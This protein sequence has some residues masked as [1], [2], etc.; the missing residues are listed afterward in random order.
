MRRSALLCTLGL[1]TCTAFSAGSADVVVIE[2]ER[3]KG[4]YYS[5]RPGEEKF[6]FTPDAAQGCSA[7][8]LERYRVRQA[9]TESEKR[10]NEVWVNMFL[11]TS[12][13]RQERLD[14]M[15]VEIRAAREAY[16]S[17]A[18]ANTAGKR[19]VKALTDAKN[20]QDLAA[21]KLNL[22]VTKLASLWNLHNLQ[23]D[24]KLG[25]LKNERTMRFIS[26]DSFYARSNAIAGEL[27]IYRRKQRES[28]TARA[29]ADEEARVAKGP[30]KIGMNTAQVLSSS[31]GSPSA[32]NKTTTAAGVKEQWVYGIKTFLYFESGKLTAIQE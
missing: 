18:K 2:A 16:K 31:W 4:L 14:A 28:E 6:T 1:F 30:V 13:A 25:D 10:E 27:A 19:N 17:T 7:A 20:A 3:E 9:Q 24:D 11:S 32:V 26:E 22:E 8:I 5:G 21:A 12:R 23:N 15:E 29:V